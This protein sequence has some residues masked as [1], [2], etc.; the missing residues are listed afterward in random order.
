MKPGLGAKRAEP[1]GSGLAATRAKRGSDRG[2]PAEVTPVGVVP[3]PPVGPKPAAAAP[4][5]GALAAPVAPAPPSAA[6]PIT[7]DAKARNAPPLCTPLTPSYI[8]VTV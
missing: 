2:G 4:R 1:V 7:Q 6:T 8:P 5:G 3:S